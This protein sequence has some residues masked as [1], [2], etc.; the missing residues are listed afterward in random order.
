MMT[1]LDLSSSTA[2]FDQYY[3]ALFLPHTDMG[4]FPAVGDRLAA[5]WRAHREQ[6]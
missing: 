4:Q 3:S 2:F 1:Y 5:A 6:A